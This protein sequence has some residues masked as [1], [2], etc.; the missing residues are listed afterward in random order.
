M[1]AEVVRA[2]MEVFQ[3]DHSYSLQGNKLNG[4]ADSRSRLLNSGVKRH[5]VRREA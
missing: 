5:C 2:Q 3:G 4:I 1:L